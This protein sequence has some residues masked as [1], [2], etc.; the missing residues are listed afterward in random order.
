MSFLSSSRNAICSQYLHG[1][2]ILI[3]PRA[4]RLYRQIPDSV[5]WICCSI[6]SSISKFLHF[7]TVHINVAKHALRCIKR[8]V[9]LCL[10]FFGYDRYFL[11]ISNPSSVSHPS[12][13]KQ[14][15][16]VALSTMEADSAT[17]DAA[18]SFSLLQSLSGYAIGYI[19]ISTFSHNI[20]LIH[21]TLKA[22]GISS[23]AQQQNIFDVGRSVKGQRICGFQGSKDP[24]DL[25][26]KSMDCVQRVGKRA[27]R[28]ILFICFETYERFAFVVDYALFFFFLISLDSKALSKLSRTQ[29]FMQGR[30]VLIFVSISFEMLFLSA[31]SVWIPLTGLNPADISS[32]EA[33]RSHAC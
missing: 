1:I 29:S 28:C 6:S 9:D 8:T 33:E 23:S 18:K 26:M 27:L 24:L 12:S 17:T 10:K 30:N 20:S 2:T 13:K 21:S 19:L 15:S 14:S 22:I 4:T 11:Y 32:E 7:S 5:I 3:I 25:L 16:V 31:K